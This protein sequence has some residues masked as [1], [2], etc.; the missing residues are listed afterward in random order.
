MTSPYALHMNEAMKIVKMYP[1]A[2]ARSASGFDYTVPGYE[3]RVQLGQLHALLAI[4]D[5]LQG[6]AVK[7]GMTHGQ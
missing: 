2:D 3:V 5:V 7:L 4:A 1:P 6:I